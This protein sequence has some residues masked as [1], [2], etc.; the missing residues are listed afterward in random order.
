MRRARYSGNV[1]AG[2]AGWRGPL[3]GGLLALALFALLVWWL[4]GLVGAD[5]GIVNWLPGR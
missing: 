2:N 3:V 4:V 1:P 5:A